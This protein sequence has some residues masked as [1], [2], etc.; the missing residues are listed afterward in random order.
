MRDRA[1]EEGDRRQPPQRATLGFD[2]FFQAHRGIGSEKK[3]LTEPDTKMLTTTKVTGGSALAG[4][5]SARFGLG[6]ASGSARRPALQQARAAQG[7]RSSAAAAL[8]HRRLASVVVRSQGPAGVDDLGKFDDD[9][10]EIVEDKEEQ[11]EMDWKGKVSRSV[12]I[13]SEPRLAL[14]RLGCPSSPHPLPR[15]G[16]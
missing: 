13:R 1:S 9:G 8:Q 16:R 12:P 6:S 3:W 4:R 14:P 10:N 5:G 15:R 7:Q 11:V 2:P